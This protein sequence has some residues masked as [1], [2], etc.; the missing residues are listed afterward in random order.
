MNPE[1]PRP[2]DSYFKFVFQDLTRARAFLEAVLPEDLRQDLDLTTLVPLRESYVSKSLTNRVSDLIFQCSSKEH[3]QFKICLL[4]EHKSRKEPY[5]RL[6]LLRYMLNHWEATKKQKGPLSPVVPVLIYHG[7]ENWTPGQF[8][9]DFGPLP[10]YL[11]DF[12]PEFRFLFI[13]LSKR[14]DLAVLTR[15][16][17][18]NAA[19]LLLKY[20]W[21]SEGIESR[22]PGLFLWLSADGNLLHASIVYI[23]TR[24]HFHPD[25][26]EQLMNKLPPRV[27]KPLKSTYDQ[28]IERERNIG[29]T[30]KTKEL[31]RFWLHVKKFS[32]PYI[33]DISGRSEEEILED[34]KKWNLELPAHE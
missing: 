31:L 18:L 32:V 19:L 23:F 17:S 1:L 10:G 16:K 22:L 4:F 26:I 5:V 21:S 34:I 14:E 3:Q 2:H 20:I 24:H 7:R 27:K 11:E 25:K 29:A 30:N 8:K 28:L 6:Q 15:L 33:A 13:N 12:I 9:S